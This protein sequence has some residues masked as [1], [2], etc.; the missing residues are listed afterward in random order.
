VTRAILFLTSLF[1]TSKDAA[2]NTGHAIVVD[3]G[4]Y[5]VG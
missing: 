4:L 3:G 5:R 2:Y 1:L